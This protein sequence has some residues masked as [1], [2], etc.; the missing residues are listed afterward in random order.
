[1]C[2]ESR[3]FEIQCSSFDSPA[4]WKR[5]D[6]GSCCVNVVDVVVRRREVE[7]LDGLR[8]FALEHLWAAKADSHH[9]P[10]QG[11]SFGLQSCLQCSDDS[12]LV[13]VGIGL[14]TL[15][16]KEDAVAPVRPLKSKR[17][18]ASSLSICLL[19]HDHEPIF[20]VGQNVLRGKFVLGP[21]ILHF[22]A[23]RP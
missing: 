15:H 18:E 3:S 13:A 8:H 11:G 4:F 2:P 7:G 6:L 19:C 20:R 23:V 14:H 1:M 22:L 5:F 12:S 17:D 16:P 21:L 9:L 10:V